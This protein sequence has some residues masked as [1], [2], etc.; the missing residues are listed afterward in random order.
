MVDVHLMFDSVLLFSI[1]ST[2]KI[3]ISINH[4]C[5][6]RSHVTISRFNCAV[7]LGRVELSLTDRLAMHEHTHL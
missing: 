6:S 4:E 3:L 7:H 2:D 5:G 1:H